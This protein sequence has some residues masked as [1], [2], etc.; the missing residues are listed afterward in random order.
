MTGERRPSFNANNALAL[1]NP[2]YSIRAL[3]HDNER[4][5]YLMRRI[6]ASKIRLPCGALQYPFSDPQMR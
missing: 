2:L 4:R 6:F 1:R 5:S 3:Q